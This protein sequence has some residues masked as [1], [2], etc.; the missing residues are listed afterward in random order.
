MEQLL[1]TLG[2]ALML[3]G[4][5][6]AVLATLILAARSVKVEGGG[7]VL[8]GPIPIIAG[9]SSRAALVAAAIALAMMGL[10]VLLLIGG[11]VVG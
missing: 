9:T 4:V 6:I 8:I 5:L 2:F 3:L 1:V 11:I 7:V 10:L